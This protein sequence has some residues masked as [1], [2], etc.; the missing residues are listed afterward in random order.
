[1]SLSVLR[2]LLRY[3]ARRGQVA[4]GTPTILRQ[5]NDELLEDV[6]TRAAEHA[7]EGRINVEDVIAAWRERVIMTNDHDAPDGGPPLAFGSPIQCFSG[8]SST[9][10]P[11]YKYPDNPLL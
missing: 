5:L 9:D 1:M 2:R 8:P 10:N 11:T 3:A 6:A 7:K 4:K